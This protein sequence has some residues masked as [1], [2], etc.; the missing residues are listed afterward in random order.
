MNQLANSLDEPRLPDGDLAFRGVDMRVDPQQLSPGFCSFAKNARFRF[1]RAEARLGMMPVRFNF[2]GATEWDVDWGQ[3]D[4]NWNIPVSIGTVYGV[5]VWED[6]NGN[7]WQLFAASRSGETIKIWAGKQGNK[8]KRVPSA[9]TIDAPSDANFPTDSQSAL[10]GFWF[11]S[12]FNKCFLHRGYSSTPLV[13]ES[14]TTGFVEASETSSTDPSV[15]SIPNSETSIYF[16]NR[17]SVPYR[18]TGS[19]KADNVAVSD[20]LSPKDYSIFNSFR[21]NQGDADN[22]VGLEKFN[23]NTI[24]VF[25]D[26]SIYAVSGLQGDWSQNATLDEITSEYGLVGR[27]SVVSVGRDLWFLSQ[28]GV[29]S[30]HR[31]EDNKLQGTD[32]PNSTPMQP[33]IDRVNWFAAKNNASA[34]YFKDRYYLSIPID[35]SYTNNCVLVYDFLNKAWSGY[36]DTT[37]KYFF[38]ADNNGSDALYFVDYSGCIGLYEYSEEDAVKSGASGSYSVDIVLSGHP[39][40]GSTLRVNDGDTIRA[41]RHLNWEDD[42]GDEV[43]LGNGDNAL[44]SLS[45][46]WD[47]GATKHW[48]VGSDYSAPCN[49]FPAQNLFL[50]FSTGSANYDQ[51]DSGGVTASQLSCGVRLTDTKPIAV[52]SNDPYITLINSAEASVT[53]Q[54]IQFEIITRAYG[55]AGGNQG[56][57]RTGLLHLSTWD[58]KYTV[59]VIT[60]GAYKESAW[61]DANGA[62]AYITKDRTKYLGFAI[63]D[64]TIANPG[65]NFRTPGREDYSV[66]LDTDEVN[67]GSCLDDSGIELSKY[68]TWANKFLT[69]RRGSYYQ[70]KITNIQGR[71]RVHSVGAE[72]TAG[73]QKHGEHGALS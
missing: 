69:N 24:I 38:T 37:V 18:P 56:R 13:M 7:Q 40:D 52:V 60:D 67:G 12:A 31:T 1:G 59:T 32:Q 62:I 23:D 70:V 64:W 11:T 47:Q 43:V 73:E 39:S 71:I 45:E 9:V 55:Y 72:K 2:L 35:G 8:V 51:W 58:P 20:I 61:V 53:C 44:L 30:I 14:L 19:A 21:I 16:Q 41:T 48:G 27:R 33:I 54:P 5:G 22:V 25:K 4:I 36:D 28:R 17:L 46:N 6:P 50:G 49:T 3:G 66:T 34:G 68:Q 63:E 65:K 10:D 42:S 15:F 57:W 29:T 26:S